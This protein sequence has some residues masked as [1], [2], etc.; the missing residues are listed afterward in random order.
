LARARLLFVF[1]N[2]PKAGGAER[3]SALLIRGLRDLGHEV[4]VLTLKERGAL[5]DELDREG[6]PAVCAAMRG[7][8]D[9]A[10]WARALAAAPL[11]PDVVV[12]RSVSAQVVGRV[13]ARI[14][15]VPHVTLERAGPGLPLRLHQVG[16]VR[17]VARS[18]DAVVA[19]SHSQIP[20]LVWRGFLEHRIRVIENGIVDPAARAGRDRQEMRR[21]LGVDQDAFVALLVGHLR[22]EKRVQL[23]VRGVAAAQRRVPRIRGLVAGEGSARPQVEADARNVD[24]VSLLGYRD[25]VADLVRAADIVCLSSDVEGMSVAL[26]E[27]MAFGKPVVA[28]RVG[29]NPEV[30]V[31]GETGFLVPPRDEAAFAAAITA[32]AEN[33]AR[34]ARMGEAGRARF[35]S[36]FTSARMVERYSMLFDAVSTRAIASKAR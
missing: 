5:L 31:D 13:A 10:G 9:W 28:T 19:V 7:R 17:L 2:L 3:Q 14:R 23:F 25:D 1:P 22:P 27:A 36:H 33:G 4:A 35:L 21:E 20:V 32:L 6:I 34:A 15:C 29:G 26:L 18:V 24:G 8:A 30:V 16:L 12:S 11:T